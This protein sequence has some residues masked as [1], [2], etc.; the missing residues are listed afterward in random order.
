MAQ[1]TARNRRESGQMLVLFVLALGVL[2]GFVAMTVDVGMILYERRSAQ[3]AA[4]AAA[5][6]A[7]AELPN[8]PSA[9]VT[10]AHEW[11]E[12]NGFDG[13]NGATITVNTPYQG[14]PDLVEVVI[15]E[16]VPFLFATVLGLE[17]TGVHAR[18]VARTEVQEG[19][20]DA[21]ILVLS[22]HDC[23]AFS[24]SGTNNLT[25]INDGAIAVNSDCAN[26]SNG[27]LNKT[28]GGDVAADG[29]IFYLE[30][31]GWTESGSGTMIPEPAP[32]TSP[33][34]DPLADRTPPDVYGTPTSPDSGGTPAQPRT[35]SFKG[36]NHTLHPGVYW[37]GIAIMSTANVT[38]EPG[39][40][41][42]AGGGLALTGSGAI[43][44]HEV[45]IYNTFDPV[46]LTS[47]YDG[48]C[49]VVDL[50]GG[51]DFTF[52]APASGPYEDIFLWQDKACTHP[53][54]FEGSGAGGSGASGIIYSPSARVDLGGTGNLGAM[55]IVTASIDIAG[56]GDML[57]DFTPYV[58][59]PVTYG[60]LKLV[61]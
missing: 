55:Q 60:P 57:I 54:T 11:A 46:N 35:K 32:L 45:F 52:T 61:E 36:G 7:V 24:K 18:A 3:N 14:D 42:M 56:S 6:A 43:A 59:I 40:Y 28:G 15:E 17:S 48:S 25:I 49:G 53:I 23:N 38:F 58:D 4:D 51:A 33:I 16:E 34:A 39:T 26:T 10:A 50:R 9:A 12:K 30:A 20:A 19:G 21:A 41:V 2:M 29:G 22:E 5:L 8:S 27:A 44:G 13:V 47:K 37:G 31:G 1:R